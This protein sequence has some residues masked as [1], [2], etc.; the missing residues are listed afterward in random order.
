MA[1]RLQAPGRLACQFRHG[2]AP[3]PGSLL[4]RLE[5]K[6]FLQEWLARI[7]EFSV[8]SGE[9]VVYGPGQVNCVERLVL[10]WPT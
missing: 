9:P 6:L 2:T 3:L 8:K 7:P 1:G 5:I 4:A 10:T